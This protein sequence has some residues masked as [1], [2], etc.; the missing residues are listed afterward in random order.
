[1]VDRVT[2]MTSLLRHHR[3][4]DLVAF[5]DGGERTSGDLLRD[6]AKIA[7]A[8]PRAT[9]GSQVAVVFESD[10]YAFAV[11]MLGAWLA[12]HAVAV[13]PHGGPRIVAGLLE[14]PEVVALVHDTLAQGH[15]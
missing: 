2:A 3:T 15:L 11:A 7:A 1:E 9:E 10:R 6:A 14:R 12:G 5:G 8:L 13:G 4:T